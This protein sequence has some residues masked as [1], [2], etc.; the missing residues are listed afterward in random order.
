MRNVILR[1]GSSMAFACLFLSLLMIS[2]NAACGNS[3]TVPTRSFVF[4]SVFGY[5]PDELAA[6]PP[7]DDMCKFLVTIPHP[8]VIASGVFISDK[9]IMT[10]GHVCDAFQQL[11]KHPTVTVIARTSTGTEFVVD[12]NDTVIDYKSDIC[13]MSH[14][15]TGTDYEIA[16]IS[17]EEPIVGERLVSVGAPAGLFIP[18]APLITEGRYSGAAGSGY[19][20]SLPAAGGC[21]GAPVFREDGTLVSIIHSVHEYFDHATFG[22]N[23]T[24]IRNII[25]VRNV[26]S[27]VDV[28]VPVPPAPAP[29]AP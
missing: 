6:C 14:K 11:S 10:A 2:C 1:F 16:T 22:A 24:S 13:V 3:S 8:I 26:R 18:S 4:L 20:Y 29:E 12:P 15:Y 25:E 21:S 23:L 19:L 9:D 27:Q 28:P 7:K 17:D 5:T